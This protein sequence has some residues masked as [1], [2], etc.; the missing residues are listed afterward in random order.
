[1]KKLITS[2]GLVA[3]LLSGHAS[4]ALIFDQNVT[5]NAI[6]GS[7]NANGSY[8]VF[9][10]NGVELGLRGKLRHNA[11]GQPENTFNSN[12][13]GTYSF[14]AG[15]APTQSTSTAVW[16]FEWSINT[17]FD[18]SGRNLSSFV[19]TL[20][21]DTDPGFGTNFVMFDPINDVNLGNGQVLWDHSF[22]NNGT[23]QGQ[24]VEAL[25]EQEYASLV[26]NNNLVQNSWKPHWF[27]DPG[28]D[29]T[30]DATYTLQLSARD[31]TGLVVTTSI[32]I[33]VGNGAVD[34]PAPASIALL[35]LGMLGVAL[36]RKVNK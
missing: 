13:D 31:D 36:R 22:G 28:F 19:Y 35:G 27:F 33:I 15:S 21:L 8:T 20:A 4:S 11:S 2:V 14:V 1:M 9:R 10:G 25:N 32:D 24:G 18:D 29:P 7:G 3:A 17:N 16:S 30:L 5:S 12:G 23:A 26:A 34:V 6:F